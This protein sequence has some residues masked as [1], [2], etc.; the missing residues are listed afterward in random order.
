MAWADMTGANTIMFVPLIGL[1]TWAAALDLRSRRIPNWLVA[2]IATAGLMQS[3]TAGATVPPMQAA[4]G[5]FAGVGLTIALFALGA[6]G[7][8]DVKLLAASGTWLGAMGVLQVFL[9][10]AIIGLALVLI[11]CAWRGRMRVLFRNSAVLI[12]NLVHIRQVGLD[13]ARATGQSCRSVDK[14]LPYAVPVLI[15]TVCL[16]LAGWGGV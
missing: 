3:L 16:V 9:G 4:Y 8:G 10:A 7:G 6:L 2:A 15:A 1:L 5:F 14:P 13:H 11:Q 12:I